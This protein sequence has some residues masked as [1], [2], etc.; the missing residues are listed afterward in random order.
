MTD[1]QFLYEVAEDIVLRDL[2]TQS[3]EP[4]Y[5]SYVSNEDVQQMKE[6][7]QKQNLELESLK[8]QINDHERLI[9]LMKVRSVQCLSAF[10]KYKDMRMYKE[11]G[12]VLKLDD[13]LLDVN[14]TLPTHM[15]SMDRTELLETT[16]QINESQNL[17]LKWR[18]SNNDYACDGWTVRKP[19]NSQKPI[20]SQIKSNQ[21]NSNQPNIPIVSLQ[22][23]PVNTPNRSP[24]NVMLSPPPVMSNRH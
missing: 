22:H 6:I 5:R 14:K 9:I 16:R 7:I 2:E 17:G 19:T 8:N 23:S 12:A 11:P 10:T 24:N 20:I 13:L 3:F 1:Q 15:K 4:D 21:L 18:K